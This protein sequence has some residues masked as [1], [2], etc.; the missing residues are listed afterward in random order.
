MNNN[1]LTNKKWTA[2]KEAETGEEVGKG[3][4]RDIHEG[5][6]GPYCPHPSSSIRAASHGARLAPL[7]AS[8]KVRIVR[9]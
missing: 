7:M 9:V 3:N 1:K 5:G 2:L 6:V 8:V 4:E